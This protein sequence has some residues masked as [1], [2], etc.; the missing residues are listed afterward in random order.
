MRSV[1]VFKPETEGEQR[2]E[3]MMEERI[4]GQVDDRRYR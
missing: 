2:G 1:L 3:N 4:A